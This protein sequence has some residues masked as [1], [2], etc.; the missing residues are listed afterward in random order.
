[1]T[2][3]EQTAEALGPALLETSAFVG[4]CVVGLLITDEFTKEQVR[5]TDDVDL[6]V[7]V[8][9]Y[10]AYAK[11]SGELQKRGF[12][13]SIQDDI[14]CRWRLGELIVDV[15]PTDEKILGYSN[16]WYAPAIESAI[17]FE[18]PSTHRIRVVN[19]PYFVATKIE[20]FKGRGNN[21]FFTSRDIE[22]IITLV[23][24]R[25]TLLEEIAAIGG[26]FEKYVSSSIQEFLRENDF[27]YAVDSA[28][29]SDTGRSTVIFDRFES[30]ARK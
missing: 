11:L 25:E 7:D 12:K 18:L 16:R 13:V 14:Q 27:E 3:A 30:L 9:N 23:D 2:T 20:A 24:G 28:V 17:W 26:C 5:A 1:M 4:G 15:M 29:R 21:D 22:D 10:A 8:M 6:I 19:A